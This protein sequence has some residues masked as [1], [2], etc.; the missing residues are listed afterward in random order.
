MNIHLSKDS[1]WFSREPAELPV[2]RNSVEEEKRNA[3]ETAVYFDMPRNYAP[4]AKGANE[5]EITSKGC[6]RQYPMVMQR[7][8]TDGHNSLM[9]LGPS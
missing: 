1:N 6:E 3:N 5:G 7:I 2:V 8:I 9:E 4:D